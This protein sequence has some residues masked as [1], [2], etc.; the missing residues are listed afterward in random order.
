M[1]AGKMRRHTRP[2]RLPKKTTSRA[3][4]HVDSRQ[5]TEWSLASGPGKMRDHGFPIVTTGHTRSEPPAHGCGSTPFRGGQD[6]VCRGFCSQAFAACSAGWCLRA[7][8]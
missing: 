2:I 1:Q 5:V 3:A 6:H 4:D 8:C 7:P